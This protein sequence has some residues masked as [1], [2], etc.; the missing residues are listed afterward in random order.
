MRVAE[1]HPEVEVTVD[2]LPAHVNRVVLPGEAE[3]VAVDRS[4]GAVRGNRSLH[5]SK[6]FRLPRLGVHLRD[7]AGGDGEHLLLSGHQEPAGWSGPFADDDGVLILI[8]D[9]VAR[10]VREISHQG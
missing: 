2:P 3:S 8:G 1:I 5:G 6:R 4:E 7:A 10:F 9:R